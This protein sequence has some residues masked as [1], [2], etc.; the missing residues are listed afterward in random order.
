MMLASRLRP[1][2]LCFDSYG[3]LRRIT[4]AH[5]SACVNRY[6]STK[7]FQTPSEIGLTVMEKRI[8]QLNANPNLTDFE[9]Y[10]KSIRFYYNLELAKSSHDARIQL[11]NFRA[12]YRQQPPGLSEDM[13]K[14]MQEWDVAL[15]K[16]NAALKNNTDARWRAFAPNVFA[17]WAD[18]PLNRRL[19]MIL[20]LLWAN[21]IMYPILR[22]FIRLALLIK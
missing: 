11:D 18:V 4:L 14:T 10:R 15:R 19:H 21:I 9:K 5:A 22:I 7:R 13:D 20:R 2:G 8:K 16:L 3:T 1:N 6:Y 17:P 12:L